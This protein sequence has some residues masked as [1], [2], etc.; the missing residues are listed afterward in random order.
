MLERHGATPRLQTDTSGPCFKG[1]LRGSSEN[2]MDLS[3]S[4][5]SEPS[6]KAIARIQGRED[7]GQTRVVKVPEGSFFVVVVWI[8]LFIYFQT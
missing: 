6:G 5:L 1:S 7:G 2:M 3:R 8:Y 4:L